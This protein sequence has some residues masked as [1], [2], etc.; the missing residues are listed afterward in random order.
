MSSSWRASATPAPTSTASAGALDRPGTRGRLGQL[1]RAVERALDRLRGDP[2][3]DRVF[4]AASELANFSL[5]WHVIGLAD[6]VRSE[7]HA[8]RALRFSAALGIE[9]V[10][11]NQGVKRLFR[12]ARP[13]RAEPHPHPLRHPTTSSFPSGHASS[14]AFAAVV[15]S[16]RRPGLAPAYLVLASVVATSRVYVGMHH[17]SD[18]LAGAGLGAALGLVARRWV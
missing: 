18:V 14:A 16:S 13:D 10:V 8:Q 12:R 17:A 6:G 5:L 4:Y 9:S 7:H 11:V 2:L 3:A 15:L 1:D